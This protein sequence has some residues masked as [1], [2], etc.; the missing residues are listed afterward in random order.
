[1]AVTVL[2]GLDRMSKDDAVYRQQ[3]EHAS[4]TDPKDTFKMVDIEIEY[5]PKLDGKRARDKLTLR[6]AYDSTYLFAVYGDN[7]A[8]GNRDRDEWDA[9]AR[10]AIEKFCATNN[11]QIKFGPRP[12]D[13]NRYNLM[14]ECG[15]VIEYAEHT[16]ELMRLNAEVAR[17]AREDNDRAIGR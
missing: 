15:R 3:V 4:R 5:G 7:P 14:A 16:V 11:L 10:N 9:G 2:A 6:Y 1:M 13:M 17:R 8:W 12:E